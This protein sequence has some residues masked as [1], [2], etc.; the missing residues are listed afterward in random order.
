[1]ASMRAA[2]QAT[3]DGMSVY[4]AARQYEVPESTLR[5]RTLGLIDE[6]AKLGT[7]TLLSESEEQGLA[8]HVNYMASI[9]YGYTKPEVIHI[10]NNYAISVGK[11]TESDPTFSDSW[12]YQFLKRSGNLQ[13]VKPRKLAIVRAKSSSKETVSKYYDELDNILTSN[14]LHD[15][16][17]NIYNMD[18]T[19][20]PLEHNPP[21]V[22][23]SKR[24]N[25]QAI[26]SP[27]G[28]NVTLIGCGNAQGN[29]LPPYYIFP[30]KR[31]N[32][33]FI[34]NTCA[35]TSGEMSDS[36]WS[37]TV[38]FK[39]YLQ[40]HFLRY[41]NPSARS[42]PVL[43]LFDGHKSHVNLA[44]HEWGRENNVIFFVLPPHTSHLLQPL[45]VG[46]FAPLK[47][48]YYRECQIYLRQNPG[49]VVNKYAVGE[50]S[51]KA[52][53]K[54]MTP[55]NLI[56][57]FQ[58]SGIHPFNRETVTN[59]Q[60]APSTIYPAPETETEMTAET[61]GEIETNQ[62]DVQRQDI[63]N[64]ANQEETSV[65][66]ENHSTDP[67]TN[68]N[69]KDKTTTRK[70]KRKSHCS[71]LE[72]G[73]AYL[74]SLT[75]TKVNEKKKKAVNRLPSV[76]GHMG[77]EVNMGILTE[78]NARKET[79]E[80]NTKKETKDKNTKK[81]KE[82]KGNSKTGSK[83]KKSL[84]FEDVQGVS[85][86]PSTSG[87]SKSVAMEGIPVSE[88]DDSDFDEDIYDDVPCCVCKQARPP[89]FNNANYLVITQWAQ[90]DTCGHWTHLKFCSTVR[91]VRNDTFFECPHC[92]PITAVQ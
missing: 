18:E 31:W 21:K 45:D 41:V 69:K 52:Y 14:G 23:C 50:M 73:N 90:C 11:K 8:E 42:N 53:I 10:A 47:A 92:N 75:V 33:L 85:P 38:T 12:F 9:G 1:M 13:V 4:R 64:N 19:N 74:K 5:D 56:G 62:D 84:K 70:T 16:P 46:C 44:L 80:K 29:F 51:S 2:F 6:N 59:F 15:K 82:T 61:N 28:Q 86:R 68:T 83:A 88:D 7:S 55:G 57:A 66:K 60:L 91:V 25:P 40:N 79:K 30:G 43:V 65:N 87:M 71:D 17:E 37:N 76:V 72:S 35:G 3:Q 49:T 20:I 32:P 26:T 78:Q 34:E 67:T 48:V 22:V 36:G 63:N 39:N 24:S 89:E 77:N 54:A 81:K 27:K 58:K